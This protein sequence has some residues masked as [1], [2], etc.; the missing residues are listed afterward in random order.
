MVIIQLF[1]S[2]RMKSLAVCS[3]EVDQRSSSSVH[4][5]SPASRTET[6]AISRSEAGETSA[7]GGQV[8]AP[9]LGECEEF[10]R[11]CRTDN[12][13]PVIPP[14]CPT[15]S[16]SEPTS[17]RIPGANLQSRAEN[18]PGCVCFVATRK[19]KK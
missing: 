5:F 17:E 19:E 2:H 18:I 4:G 16:V 8:I 12:V 11:H 10:L 6:P 9:A 14:V 7:S 3:S 13:N 1:Q 15:I